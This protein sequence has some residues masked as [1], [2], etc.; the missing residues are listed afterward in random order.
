MCKLL[1]YLNYATNHTIPIRYSV[2]ET[3]RNAT[4]VRA[5]RVSGYVINEFTI[6][7]KTYFVIP[8]HHAEYTK[9]GVDLTYTDVIYC[10]EG[11]RILSCDEFI[12][13]VGSIEKK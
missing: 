13:L 11:D 7:N 3:I 2:F 1:R 5:T 10:M 9:D 12:E 8:Y 6:D 4:Q